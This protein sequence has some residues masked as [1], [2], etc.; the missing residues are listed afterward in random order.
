[1]EKSIT[2][3]EYAENGII[4]R[5]DFDNAPE[6]YETERDEL[7]SRA[8]SFSNIITKAY[9]GIMATCMEVEA[10]KLDKEQWIG[11]NVKIEITPIREEKDLFFKIK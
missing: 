8:E 6:I 1:M 5:R 9:G 11:F 4:I 3:M 2:K 10:E 7:T